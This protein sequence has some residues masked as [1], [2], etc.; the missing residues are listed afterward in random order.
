MYHPTLYEATQRIGPY[1]SHRTT[2]A[3]VPSVGSRAVS[4][5]AATDGSVVLGDVQQVLGYH[6]TSS[7]SPSHHQQ[8]S[9]RPQ[10]RSA[11]VDSPEVVRQGWQGDWGGVAL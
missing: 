2:F 7:T 11:T 1:P 9:P 8:L 5:Q 6:P 10:R 4:I 3:H